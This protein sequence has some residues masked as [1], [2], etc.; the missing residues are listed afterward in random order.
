MQKRNN[1]GRVKIDG[2][3]AWCVDTQA[4]CAIHVTGLTVQFALGSDGMW[5]GKA[6]LPIPGSLFVDPAT[7]ARLMRE[8]GEAFR[9]ALKND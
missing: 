7:L 4:K 1:G 3:K 8:A 9:K 6:V 2:K 5:E